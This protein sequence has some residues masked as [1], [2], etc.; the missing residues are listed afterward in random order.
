MAATVDP[1]IARPPAQAFIGPEDAADLFWN[2]GAMAQS[3][4]SMR[5]EHGGMT[6]YRVLFDR[7]EARV[8]RGRDGYALEG[9]AWYGGDIDKL[10][11]KAELGGRRSEKPDEAEV[12]ALWSHAIDPWFDVQSGV[13][14]DLRP[15]RRGHLALGVQG[16]APYWIEVEAAAFLSSE[17]DLTGRI[18]AEHDLRLTQRLV[19]QPRA[20]LRLAARDVEEEG[21]GAGLSSAELGLRLRFQLR[22]EF[23]PYVGVSLDQ[24]FGRTRRFRRED[25][26]NASDLRLLAGVR[27]WF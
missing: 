10:W 8:G 15:E 19:L 7:V 4:R 16:L 13:R 17:G 25:G 20:E 9:D 14:V 3:R 21:I 26:E 5:R 22:P 18:E 12:Q 6:A 27:A 24:A 1:P 11:L 2:E 23:A